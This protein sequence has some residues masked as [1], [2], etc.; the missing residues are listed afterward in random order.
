M[1]DYE[2]VEEFEK[3]LFELK[4]ANSWLRA[5]LDAEE[6]NIKEKQ[7]TFNKF[8]KDFDDIASRIYLTI[9][10]NEETIKSLTNK[11]NA[12]K[13]V[14]IENVK[15]RKASLKTAKPK[16]K[17]EPIPMMILPKK[18]EKP[19]ETIEELLEKLPISNNANGKKTCPLCNKEFSSQGFGSHFKA[20][21]TKA[22]NEF[23]E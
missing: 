23:G 18:D 3:K 1:K 12:A 5:S 16:Q 8:K 7:E 21:A 6:R 10:K 9:S 19:E 22:V 20:C 2:K 17:S 11:L 13:I 14:Q 4:E 15:K